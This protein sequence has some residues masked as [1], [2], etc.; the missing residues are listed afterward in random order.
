MSVA[1]AE[2]LASSA[3][4]GGGLDDVDELVEV[5]HPPSSGASPPPVAS[6]HALAGRGV[7]VDTPVA[8]SFA[9]AHDCTAGAAVD[10]K[11]AAV[12]AAGHDETAARERFPRFHL[13]GTADEHDHGGAADG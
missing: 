3:A 8:L 13:A 2:L 10:G 12:F 5:F 6:G 1:V 7:A 11:R 4:A 9:Q